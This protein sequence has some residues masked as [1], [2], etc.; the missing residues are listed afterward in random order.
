MYLNLFVDHLSSLL[1]NH[2]WGNKE[3]VHLRLD[4]RRF[5]YMYPQDMD[6]RI[7]STNIEPFQ[8]HTPEKRFSSMVKS[9]MVLYRMEPDNQYALVNT[10]IAVEG[11]V[12]VTSHDNHGRTYASWKSV[13]IEPAAVD[14]PYRLLGPYSISDQIKRDIEQ[15]NEF[16]YLKELFEKANIAKRTNK[17]LANVT[18]HVKNDFEGLLSSDFDKWSIAKG[19]ATS[20][21]IFSDEDIVIACDHTTIRKT[22]ADKVKDVAWLMIFSTDFNGIQLYI[23]S[24]KYGSIKELIDLILPSFNKIEISNSKY[25]ELLKE[26]TTAEKYSQVNERALLSLEVKST[27]EKLVMFSANGTLLHIGDLKDVSLEQILAYNAMRV[28]DDKDLEQL[29]DGIRNY[30]RQMSDNISSFY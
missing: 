23:N 8:E 14:N 7:M 22:M 27:D 2:G 24:S 10:G 13:T 12:M 11:E 19:D 18:V 29:G 4:G 28:L 16:P 15:L 3:N 5:N 9:D 1:I 25:L 30:V 26:L 21:Y 6:N 17:G 20:W